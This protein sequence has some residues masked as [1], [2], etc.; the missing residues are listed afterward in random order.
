MSNSTH[1][2]QM[3]ALKAAIADA[4]ADPE[5]VTERRESLRALAR[6]H[7]LR[8]RIDRIKVL[9][10]RGGETPELAAELKLRT[11]ELN[12]QALKAEGLIAQ[13]E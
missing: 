1:R 4:A 6:A 3:A 5:T 8:A 13:K 9:I 11:A 12:F 7:R 2:R 10:E